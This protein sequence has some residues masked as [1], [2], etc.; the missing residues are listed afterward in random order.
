MKKIYLLLSIL[1]LSGVAA[2]AGNPDRQG[3]AGAYE[4]LMMPWARSAGLNGLVVSNVY[5]VESMQINPAGLS[6]INKTEIIAAHTRYLVGSGLSLNAAGVAQRLSESGVIGFTLMQVDFGDI[7]LTTTDR[8]EGVGV[9]FKPTFM[10][11]VLSYSHTFSKRISCALAVKLVT[12]QIANAGA[13]GV[14]F[15]A[16][17]QYVT[18][19]KDNIRFGVSLRNVGTKMGFSGDGLSYTATEPNGDY[20]LTVDRRASGF[21][22]PTQLN[23]GGSYDFLID[24]SRHRITTSAQF[25][26]NAYTRDQYGIGLEY[27]F[28]KLFML[29][30]AYKI[31]PKIF[32]EQMRT[33]AETGL[34]AGASI[35]VPLKKGG[36][37]F[38]GFDYAYKA[39]NPWNGSHTIG[40]RLDL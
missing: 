22:L 6:R 4:L 5:G 1:T 20:P 9:N 38:F 14:C 36:D 27:A 31:E 2:F 19:P 3:E 39:S 35:M 37:K 30:V 34:S 40:I 15:D 18:G 7:P 12:E 11:M 17:V 21:D 8:P 26:A 10:N 16:G 33:N 25:T 32:D 13:T 28:R 24:S 29:R 23:I